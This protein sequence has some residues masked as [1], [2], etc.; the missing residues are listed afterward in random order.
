MMADIHN[1]KNV[2][3]VIT[4][5]GGNVADMWITYGNA[6]FGVPVALGVTGVMASDY[7]PYLKSGQILGLIP[8]VKGAAEYEQLVGVVGQ[9]G[10]RDAVSGDH[11]SGN[12][13]LHGDYQHRIRRPAPGAVIN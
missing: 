11:P 4:F 3:G 10:P 6:K 2:K 7:Y 13:R 9:G 1:Y 8:G 12:P 5:A